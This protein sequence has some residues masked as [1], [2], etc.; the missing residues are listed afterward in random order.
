MKFTHASTAVLFVLLQA[1]TFAA[2]PVP[3]PLP[4]EKL[5]GNLAQVPTTDP[6]P[7][8]APT[9][10]PAVKGVHPRLLFSPSDIETLKGKI[11]SDPILQKAFEGT[12]QWAALSPALTGPRPDIVSGDDKGVGPGNPWAPYYQKACSLAY[13][14]AIGK[15][16]AVKQKIVDTLTAM[17][18]TEH[19]ADANNE[20]DSSMGAAE[21]M[22]MV[23]FLYDAVY[24]D[25]APDLRSKLA[26]K[27]FTMARRMYYLGHKQLQLPFQGK[28]FW[29]SDPQP[30]HRWYRDMGLAACVLVT[31]DEKDI[32]AGY[33]MQGLKEEMDFV[34]KWYPSDGDCHEG[35]GYQSYGILSISAAFTMMDRNLGTTYLKDTGIRHA[36]QQQLYFW[37]PGRMSN[38][39]WGDDPNKPG[40]GFG[41]SDAAFLLGAKLSHDPQAQAA[42]L[43]KLNTAQKKSGGQ[44][45]LL[46]WAVLAFYDPSLTPSDYKAIPLSKLLPDIGAASMRDSWDDNAVVFTFKCGPYGGYQLNQ[47]RNTVTSNGQPHYVNL[48]H[49]DPDAN[50]FALAVGNGFAFH[51]GTY[52]NAD[53]PPG[54]VTRDH[55]TIT[56]DDKGQVSE[57]SGYTQP[58][59]N[60]DMTKFSYLTGWKTDTKGHV[61]I[62]GEAGPAYCGQDYKELRASGNKV[63]PAQLKT[64][65]RTAIW[66]PKEYILLLDNIASTGGAHKITWRGS[67]PVSKITDGKGTATTET[68]TPVPFQIVSD[69][70]LQYASVPMTLLGRWGDVSVQQIQVTAKADAV[71]FATV[72]DPWKTN[73]TVKLTVNGAT[74]TVQVSGSGFND[75]WTWQEP[76]SATTPSVIAGTRSGSTLISLTEADKAPTK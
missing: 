47:Y 71:K 24:N 61:I 6:S 42:M 4:A 39:S 9:L 76:K 25:L 35:A 70:V 14:Y 40:S 58:V 68:G 28:G 7:S 10:L 33:L 55:S 2:P 75:V 65:R 43:L 49:D 26:Q 64:Y 17:L 32:Q 62:E 13:V 36:W 21:N 15:E 27:I 38:I 74:T 45:L 72:I 5:K 1:S 46:N 50:E 31:C 8:S 34:A 60:A 20:V 44:P 48:A 12:K 67:A 37:V 18:N 69:K 16:P 51:P 57:G 53:K 30:N 23:A 3:G 54:K 52:S 73:A 22:F 66:M 63:A 19:W 59:G 56:V 41:Y 29:T 11:S